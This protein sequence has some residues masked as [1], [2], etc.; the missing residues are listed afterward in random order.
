MKTSTYICKVNTI[1]NL[2]IKLRKLREE[3]KWSQSEIA[4][5]L[6]ISQSAYNKWESGQSKPTLE[7]LRKLAEI[8]KIS[9]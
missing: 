6:D 7:N 5:Q 2:D 1:M 8:Y 4:C 9:F 3:K